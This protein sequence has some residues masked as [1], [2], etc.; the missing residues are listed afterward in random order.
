MAFT[1]SRPPNLPANGTRDGDPSRP[2]QPRNGDLLLWPD[3]V[4]AYWADAACTIRSPHTRKNWGYTYRRLQHLHP[5][6]KVGEFSADDLVAYVTQRAGTAPTGRRY[7]LATSASPCPGCS[8]GPTSPAACPTDPAAQ[9]GRLVRIP[10]QRARAPHWLNDIQI[11]AL[12]ATT[13]RDRLADR[14]DRVVLMLGLLAGLRTGE[15]CALRWRNVNLRA[16]LLRFLGKGGEP[17]IVTMPAQLV[18]E[19]ER[20]RQVVVANDLQPTGDLPVVCALRLSLGP[21]GRAD[22][23]RA[24]RHRHHLERAGANRAQPRCRHRHP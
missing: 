16:G 14:R 20:W 2:L 13:N 17:A 4:D 11:A 23:A 10:H 21:R 3:S 18:D 12:I 1:R 15:M 9:L 24:P 22:A 6:K 7:R 5:D 8:A 19:L